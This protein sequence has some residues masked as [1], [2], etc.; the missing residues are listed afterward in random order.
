[1][2]TRDEEKI[3]RIQKD[4]MVTLLKR[5]H[6]VLMEKYELF[7]A[8]NEQLEKVALEKERLYNEMKIDTDRLSS[9]LFRAQKSSE[10]LR[11]LNE[12]L[13]AKLRKSDE[14]HRTKDAEMKSL[15][16]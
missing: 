2:I 9:D 12:I 5:N 7:R 1:M 4:Q 13:D 8:Q 15:K 11:S 6:D 10:E 3:D 16:I 14:S